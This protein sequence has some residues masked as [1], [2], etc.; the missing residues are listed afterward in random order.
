M[1]PSLFVRS[2]TYLHIFAVATLFFYSFTQVDL[3][4]TIMR[5]QFWQKI[6]QSF[7]SIG[8]FNRPL[9][10]A[11]Y[12]SIISL[13]FVSYI[14]F[15]WLAM[16]KKIQRQYI[17]KVI[18]I[19]TLILFFSYNAF[20]YDLFNY[21]FDAKIVTYYQQNPYE[22]KAL[23]YQNDP[24]LSFMHWTHRVYPYG[25]TWLLL[26][27]PLSFLGIQFFLPTLLLFKALAAV[28]FIGSVYYI[29][30][31][32]R[33]FLPS[34]ELF[35]IVFFGLNPLVIIESLVSA[36]NDIVMMFF[37][38]MSLYLLLEKKYIFSFVM[39]LV[40][41]GVK[42]ATIFLLPTFVAFY[43][44]ARF[45]FSMRRKHIELV[46]F[47]TATVMII[48]LLL[49]VNREHNFQPWYLLFVLPF[50]ALVARKYYIFIPIVLFS[51]FSLL[52]YAP[53]LYL[54]NWDYP[55]PLL[56]YI[57]LAVSTLL[58]LAAVVFYSAILFVRKKDLFADNSSEVIE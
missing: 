43:L 50:T 44:L 12:G 10:T 35:G 26:S 18:G 41:V 24:M 40:S 33:K 7:Q 21:I 56:I 14:S 49:A 39:L 47:L 16:K 32:Y 15:L 34:Y 58:S 53:F 45:R 46:F 1:K 19:T 42:F 11:L 31:I 51:F 52:I 55:V 27:V 54:G 20:S 3:G 2:V 17:W 6:Q 5:W 22:H 28:S 38:V 13:L 4:L 9:S 36:H 23:D 8:Y 37:A 29:G 48:P 25:P 57:L 30:K